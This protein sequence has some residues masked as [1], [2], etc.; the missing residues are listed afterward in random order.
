MKK[1]R[2]LFFG[3]L[4]GITIFGT[5]SFMSPK[6]VLGDAAS[7]SQMGQM[8]VNWPVQIFACQGNSGLTANNPTCNQ[9]ATVNWTVMINWLNSNV[10]WQDLPGV[11]GAPYSA[12]TWIKANP[13]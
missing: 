10:N 1:F 12:T 2:G 13:Q 11:T 5:L 7:L 6:I 4:A 3:L 9:E 8:S